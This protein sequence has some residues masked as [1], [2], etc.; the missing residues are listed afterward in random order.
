MRY[1]I[2]KNWKGFAL[3]CAGLFAGVTASGCAQTG[4]MTQNITSGYGTM[5]SKLQGFSLAE[6][7][8]LVTDHRK[9]F[10]DYKTTR[11]VSNEQPADETNVKS[12]KK[13]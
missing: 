13:K 1:F 10:E 2:N 5:M 12:M 6:E 4:A 8:Q 11:R 3:L 7:Q 9:A